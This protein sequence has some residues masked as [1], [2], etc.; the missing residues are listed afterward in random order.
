[1]FRA[2]VATGAHMDP[3]PREGNP[4]RSVG[5][6]R[7]DVGEVGTMSILPGGRVGPLTAPGDR[8]TVALPLLLPLLLP[9]PC[10]A[11]WSLSRKAEPGDGTP[12]AGGDWTRP[13][14]ASRTS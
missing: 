11:A 9:L 7:R 10:V 2:V 5:R 13:A 1:M 14:S 12:V 3:P 8:S 6:L 4:A